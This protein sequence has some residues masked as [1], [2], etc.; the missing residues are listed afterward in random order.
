MSR[1]LSTPIPSPA[2]PEFASATHTL[3]IP[4]A[5]GAIDNSIANLQASLARLLE[6]MENSGV[7]TADHGQ[8]QASQATQV[9]ISESCAVSDALLMQSDRVDSAT[10]LLNRLTARLGI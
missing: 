1:P 9:E 2:N 3:P 5:M 8:V 10:V 7:L 4:A 6:R